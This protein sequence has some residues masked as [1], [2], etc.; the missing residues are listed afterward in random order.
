[1]TQQSHS[2]KYNKKFSEE[3]KKKKQIPC[4]KNMIAILSIRENLWYI[5]IMYKIMYTYKLMYIFV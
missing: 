3:N 1:M 2:Y 4:I 5:C